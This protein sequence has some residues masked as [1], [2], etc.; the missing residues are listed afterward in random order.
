MAEFEKLQELWRQLP[1]PRTTPVD[2]MALTRAVGRYGRRQKWINIAKLALVVPLLSWAFAR[3]H[4]S[5]WVAVGLVIVIVQVA[6]LLTID[7]RNQRAVSRMNFAQPSAAFVRHAI[8]QLM[9]HREPFR[10]HFWPFLISLCTGTNLM[11]LGM[12]AQSPM[13]WRIFWHLFASL[14]PFLAYY[15]GAQVRRKRFDIECRS[16]VARLTAMQQALEERSE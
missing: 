13:S 12:A 7:W 4:P 15:G 6:V 14:F 5:G 9:E 10:K 8:G 11:V 2:A 1:A 3:S 16:L